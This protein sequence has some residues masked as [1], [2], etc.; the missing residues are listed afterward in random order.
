MISFNQILSQRDY[1]CTDT[2]IFFYCTLC[3]KGVTSTNIL[4]LLKIMFSGLDFYLKFLLKRRLNGWGCLPQS[5]HYFFSP[6]V[7]AESQIQNKK[8][9]ANKKFFPNFHMLCPSPPCPITQTRLWKHVFNYW[10]LGGLL[11]FCTVTGVINPFE[12]AFI[13]QF[14]TCK[15]FFFHSIT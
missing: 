2:D 15:Y 4:Y 7:L 9:Y 12:I 10:I 3:F 5:L 14:L 8:N 6:T 13:C 11:S 1:F